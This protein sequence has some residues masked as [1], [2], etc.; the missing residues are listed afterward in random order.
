[1]M[2]LA[3]LNG[4]AIYITFGIDIQNL[5]IMIAIGRSA[6]LVDKRKQKN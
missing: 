4:L 1:M 3:A 2:W 6:A 5:F